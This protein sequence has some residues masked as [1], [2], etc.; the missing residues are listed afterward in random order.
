MAHKILI[1]GKGFIGSRIQSFLHCDATTKMIHSFRDVESL[2]KKYKPRTIINC[3]GITGKRN[4][5]DCE[6]NKDST[7]FAN[8]YIPMLLAEVAIRNNIKLVHISSGCI[9]CYDYVRSR[10]ITEREVPDFFDL[11][12]SRSKIYAERALEILS[13]KSNVLIMRLRIP[14]DNRPHRRNILTKLIKYKKI[15]DI[16]NSVTYM[17][18]FLRAL[19]HLMARDAR[20]L[21]NVVNKGALRYPNLI[22][23]YKKYNPQLNFQAV[24]FKKLNLVRTNLLLSTK[25]LEQSGFKVRNINS[26][27]EECV[28]SYLKF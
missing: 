3:I 7:L 15:I 24:P 23:I 9:Y 10:P 8:S 17:P 19:K 13:S 1:F 2:I 20:G 18:D 12:Y 25:K 11:Y 5:D 6:I 21:Y 28:K 14:L 16:P 27:L 22:K 4:V 26:V